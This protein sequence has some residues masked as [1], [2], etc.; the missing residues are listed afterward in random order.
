[1]QGISKVY[2]TTTLLST[3]SNGIQKECATAF[4]YTHNENLY[5]VTNK[6][7]LYGDDFE[8]QSVPIVDSIKI[9]LHKNPRDLRQVQEYVINLFKDDKKIS[10]E[11]KYTD[12]DVILIPITI[13][14]KE[15]VI[16][17]LKKE[18]I[19]SEDLVVDDFET[20]FL[21]G[22]PH[23]WYDDY[24]HLPVARVGHLSSSFNGHFKGKPVMLGDM[25]THEGMSGAPVFMRLKNFITEIKGQE[26]FNFGKERRVLVGIYSGQYE[27]PKIPKERTNL[28]NIWFARMIPEILA[29]N[30]L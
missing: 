26:V 6:H 3:F 29:F 16:N 9:I 14:R 17:S 7:V 12:V 15:F 8:N 5:L 24:N 19:D 11:H 18:F 28:I 13:D 20:I 27:I 2:L 22:Y 23:G 30:G 10:L 21:L 4:F 1:M 25:M